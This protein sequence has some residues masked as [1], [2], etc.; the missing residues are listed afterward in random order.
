MYA[1]RFSNTTA[2]IKLSNYY[3]ILGQTLIYKKFMADCIDIH[4]SNSDTDSTYE[5]VK[6]L[7]DAGADVNLQNNMDLRH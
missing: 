7:L 2:Q 5:T 1:V 6:L 3:W 4:S